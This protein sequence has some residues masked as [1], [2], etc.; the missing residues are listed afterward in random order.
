MRQRG[1]NYTTD[2]VTHL[3]V[4]IRQ[5][6]PTNYTE[7]LF[8]AEEHNKS[9]NKERDEQSVKLKFNKLAKQAMGTGNFPIPKNVKDAKEIQKLIYIKCDSSTLDSSQ[10]STIDAGAVPGVPP[11]P[12]NTPVGHGHGGRASGA[13]GDVVVARTPT[14]VAPSGFVQEYASGGSA[15]VP[16]IQSRGGRGRGYATNNFN[17]GEGG[18]GNTFA[19]FLVH[20]MA[21]ERR[22]DERRAERERRDEERRA[23]RERQRE[24]FLASLTT[25][26]TT[27][28]AS[29]LGSFQ[30]TRKNKRKKRRSSDS[31]SSKSSNSRDDDDSSSSSESSSQRSKKKK[32]KKSRKKKNPKRKQTDDDNKK[33]DHKD[34]SE[35]GGNAAPLSETAVIVSQSQQ[36]D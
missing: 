10:G 3:L 19:S 30:K 25:T 12:Q 28:V 6:L 24:D 33:K 27:T 16:R 15:V 11:P 2:E 1:G 35:L 26:V 23:E 31:V 18:I 4:L 29:L 36:H 8:I 17:S 7:W 32:T 34:D 21:S 5:Y 22:D 13:A 14:G 20:Q 9:F